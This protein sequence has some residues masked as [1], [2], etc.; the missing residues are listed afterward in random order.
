M[1]HGLVENHP[2]SGDAASSADELLTLLETRRSVAMTL[3]TD[4]GPSKDQLRRMLTIAARVPDHG[5]LQ[6]WRFIVIDGEARK[7]A[8]ER[9]AP[10][11]A[12]ENEAM[13][14]AQREKFTG[15]ISRVFTHAP[16]IVIVVSRTDQ[17]ARIPAWEQDLSAGAV[18]MNLL[19]AAHALGFAGTWLTGWAAYSAGGHRLLGISA[20]EKV[21]GIVYV[22]TAKEIPADRKRPDIDAIVT[23]WIADWPQSD[24]GDGPVLAAD[25]H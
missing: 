5:A 16:L 22:G 17:A 25:D 6:P 15:V 10:I 12:A 1:S 7:H 19:H 18:C 8:S 2:R 24:R 13:E 9:L 14:P 20:C 21:A 11:F 3:L 23:R 4:P